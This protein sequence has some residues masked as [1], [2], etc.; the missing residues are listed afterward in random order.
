VV[1]GPWKIEN[2]FTRAD[3]ANYSLVPHSLTRH[4]RAERENR[5][6]KYLGN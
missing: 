4:K 5:D 3:D 6:K 2:V 1:K